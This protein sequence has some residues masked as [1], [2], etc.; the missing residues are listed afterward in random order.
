M[1]E[2]SWLRR[3]NI[4]RWILKC[5]PSN[6]NDTRKTIGNVAGVL[7]GGECNQRDESN[8]GLHACRK[9]ILTAAFRRVD[10]RVGRNETAKQLL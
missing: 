8:D 10:R 1:I 3:L 5:S 2:E 4:H 7:T 9:P 6:D